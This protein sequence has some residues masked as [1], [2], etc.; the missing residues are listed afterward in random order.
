MFNCVNA[1]VRIYLTVLILTL[2]FTPV[3]A[4]SEY[5]GIVKSNGLPL[6]GATVIAT[7]GNHR[8]VTTSDER[9]VF[10]FKNL[11]DGSWTIQVEML[12]FAT[13]SR[14]IDAGPAMPVADWDLKLLPEQVLRHVLRP[15]EQA[16]AA[17]APSAPPA[18]SKPAAAAQRP[19]T[20]AR[21]SPG[22]VPRSP[23]AGGAAAQN[24][25]SRTSE[26]AEYQRLQVNQAAET[27]GF[28]NE[29]TIAEA[30]VADLSQSAANSFIVQGSMSTALA[31]PR[32][33]DWGPPGM[34]PGMGIEGGPG[35]MGPGM[36]G[37][38]G[39]GG[40]EGGPQAGP[41]GRAGGFGGGR[42]GGPGGPGGPG[43]GGPGGPGGRFPGRFEGPRA[44]GRQGRPDW[45]GRRN[46]MAFGNARRSNNLY[47]G[48]LFF[49]LNNSVWDART[50]SV[51]GAN[52][53]KPAYASARAG[54]MFGGPLQIPKLISRERHIMF[55]IN[56]QFQRNRTGTIS[57][58]VNMPTAL[59]RIGDF[60]Q[61]SVL[62]SPVAIYD[63][64][65]GSPFPG[66]KIPAS[67]LDPAALALLKFFPDPNLPF[68]ARNY[69]T[70]WTGSNNSHNVNAR[71]MNIRVG[72]KDRF[73]FGIGYQGSDNVSPNLFQFIDTGSGR[74]IN[75]NLGWSRNITAHL[76]N[77]LHYT[78]SRNRQQLSPFFA[79]RENI[80]AEL[81]IAGTSQNPMNWGPP[82]LGFTNYAGLTDGNASLMRNQTGSVN[83]SLILNRG[84]H[85]M[86]FGG[87]FRRM[88]F[89]QFADPNGRGSYTFTGAGTSLFIDGAAQNGTG[90]DFADFLLG[91]PATGSLRYGNADKYFRG[92]GY[93]V[94]VN[95]DWRVN[96]KFTINAGLRWD[97]ATPFTELY[98]RL[99]NLDIA[100]GF[101]IVTPV[102]AG[103]FASQYGPLPDALIHPDRNNFAPRIGFAWRPGANRSMVVRGGYGVYY[104]TSVYNIIAGNMAQQP[105]F[106]QVL[107]V[108]NS[109]TTPLT[110]ANGFLLASSGL[111]ES[112]Y[113]ID[114]NYQIGY[115]QTWTLSVQ[116][117]LPWGMFATVGYLGTKGTRLDQQFIPNSV[118]P[119]AVE[120]ALPH[121]FIFE[122]SNGN[123]IYHA[124]QFQLNR[125]FRSGI[126]AHASY[127]FSKSIDNAGTG[128]R[129]QGNTPVAQN[130]LDLSAE[131]GLS[132]FDARHNL[133]LQMQYSTGMGVSGGTLANGF[134]GALLKDWTISGTVTARSGTP[135]TAIV[136]GNRSQ[137]SGTAVTNTVRA[138]ATGLP[139][140]APEMLF[141]T[142]AF[143]A[144]QAGEWGNAG[145]NT[146]PGPTVF[147]L[148][149][150]VGRIFRLGERRSI[151]LQFQA[152][153]VL[154]HVTITNWGTVLG[155]TNYGLATG[156]AQMRQ[157]TANLR[158]RF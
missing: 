13:A 25:A 102:V 115:A 10:D 128:G 157:I 7:Q 5:R 145:R 112:T 2:A 89:N 155:A 119:G 143:A 17:Q 35:G 105:P 113:A 52:V 72:S 67:R 141:N 29:N 80:A 81:G 76:I 47:M 30:E 135:F 138:N 37:A 22:G 123:S 137:V 74:S 118:P 146:I 142:A 98:G 136:G 75:A 104:N 48:N 6:P 156:A 38:P 158:F 11:A 97:Y 85:T 21:P 1:R 88:Q 46:A 139:V 107:N 117:D 71:V 32:I 3:L 49:S 26:R 131:R 61:T 15:E 114:P 27:N 55:T 36:A 18:A 34:G 59:E 101:S 94:F 57:Q 154:N 23:A 124:A 78:F 90:Y 64:T 45:Q 144:P 133:S 132:S 103:Q 95:D 149:G 60:S 79:N 130:W 87:G 122:T 9:G 53:D 69:Q 108:T 151:D 41:G 54:I 109:A 51:T 31:M 65:T 44:G 92:S 93:D 106:A 66:N 110:I 111:S 116:H 33:N 4:A 16:A 56:F 82:N 152:Q 96:A 43:F 14:H 127:Q 8:L 73:N 63:P 150:A 148:N 100:P 39:E 62:G 99:V 125:R 70:S 86:T 140:T 126:G 28:G 83:E 12:G 40:P 120:S 147:F 42:F 134:K 58:P 24:G 50:F 84:S 91:T 20:G 129:G 121:S 68:A 77:N 19:Q 153:N